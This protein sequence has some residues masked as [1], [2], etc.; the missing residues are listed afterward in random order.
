MEVLA[1]SDGTKGFFMGGYS[2]G[3]TNVIDYVTIAT[4]ANATDWGDLITARNG[5][6]V[7]Q[8]VELAPA[9]LLVVGIILLVL[10][11]FQ[12]LNI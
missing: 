2:G 4:D 3:A 5:M 8:L 9:F 11:L 6:V 7:T 1:A 12:A 10:K